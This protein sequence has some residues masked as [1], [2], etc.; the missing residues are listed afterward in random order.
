MT[1]KSYP[2][3][4]D[5]KS[6]AEKTVYGLLVDQ[7]PDDA[8]VYCNIE[9][10]D[11][12]IRRELDFLVSIPELGLFGLEVKGGS[13]E[14]EGQIWKQWDKASHSFVELPLAFQLDEERRMVASRLKGKLTKQPTIAWFVVTPDTAFA[15]DAF[16]PSFDRIQIISKSEIDTLYRIAISELKRIAKPHGYSTLAQDIVRKEFANEFGYD[17]L[18]ES[19]HSRAKLVDALSVEQM[20]LLDFM[21][22]NSRFLVKGGPGSGKTVLAIEHSSRLADQKLRVGLVCYNR[23][24]G[25]LL[26]HR[27]SKLDDRKKPYFVGSILEDLP[28]KWQIQITNVSSPNLNHYYNQQLPEQLLA[29]TSNL[30]DHQ[31]FDAWIVDE[32]QDLTPAHWE[33]LKASL[34]DPENGIIH[35]FGDN[36]QNLFHGA[37]DLPWFYATG[38]LSS[39]LRSTKTI[40]GVLKAISDNAG[41]PAGP[42]LGTTPEVIFVDHHDLAERVAD[43]YAE[44]LVEQFGWLP[45]DIVVITTRQRHTKQLAQL[46]DVDKYWDDFFSGEQIMYTNVNTFKGLERPVAIVAVN[47]FPATTDA[48]QKLYVAMSRARD[49]LILVGTRDEL[50]AIS[51]VLKGFAEISL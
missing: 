23:G 16:T 21:Q 13:I 32:A 49:D 15:K 19:S 12:Q 17:Q 28:S 27:I 33:I 47:G 31:K 4:P 42:I 43:T 6:E 26:K 20:Y 14:I 44:S 1:F 22:D 3:I 50:S 7:L 37:N 46:D 11:G 30:Q 10:F 51:E 29:H 25:K 2:D 36:E 45:G 8:E 41:I 39:N 40:A 9:Y 38:K 24:L 18:V 34:R 48:V 35:A 5:L